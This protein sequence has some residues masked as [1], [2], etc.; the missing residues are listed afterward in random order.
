MS[1]D[2]YPD[3]VAN[4]QRATEKILADQ[5]YEAL[6]L[7]SGAPQ[8]R[9]RFDDQSWPLMPTPAFTHW[10]PLVEA[11]SYVV[12]RQGRKPTLV[13]TVV[14]DF[15]ETVPP[16][17]SEHF[18][19]QF[20]VVTVGPGHAGDVL[21]G[22]KVAVVT[23]DPG[24]APP[25]EVNPATLIA[26]LDGTRTRKTAYEIECLAIAS[27]RAVRGHKATEKKFQTTDA[28]ELELHLTYLD[29]SEQ[30]DPTTPYKNIVAL[31]AH[32]AVLHYV[33]YERK[34]V[35]GDTSLL[36]D[37][38]ARCNGYGS[39]ITRSYVRGTS[40][41]AKRFG[42]LIARMDQLQQDVLKRIKPGLQYEELHDES[43]RLLGDMLKDVGIGKASGQELVAKGIT[44]ALFPHGLGH[45]LGVTVHDVGMKLRPPRPENK[46]LR[47]TS[48]IEVGHVFTIEPGIYFID[49]LVGPLREDAERGPLI[50]WKLVDELRPFGGIRIEDNV[51]VEA[52]GIRN[53][54]REAYK[55]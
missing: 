3:H 47:N 6:I 15:W 40:G 42:E 46:F 26:A 4:L 9:N 10:C 32:S 24:Q 29:A 22:G 16:P 5:G 41:P 44:R 35:S 55:A 48:T 28:S 20:D 49:A 2:N 50:D 1:F 34:K 12:V 51:V 53:L 7:C 43:H 38:G 54:T 14:D 37:A 8:S 36:V 45:S 27:R 19:E 23:R 11:D 18:W 13:R 21:P 30:D 33:A 31:G 25:G 39:D 17:E 52:D